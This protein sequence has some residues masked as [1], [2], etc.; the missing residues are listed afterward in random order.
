M[1]QHN[2]RQANKIHFSTDIEDQIWYLARKHPDIVRVTEDSISALGLGLFGDTPNDYEI[3]AILYKSTAQVVFLDQSF[4]EKWE[5]QAIAQKKSFFDKVADKALSNLEI[6]SVI[7]GIIGLIVTLY[8]DVRLGKW[9]N[10]EAI[11][12]GFLSGSAI[13]IG[14]ILVVCAFKT[15]LITRLKG[16]NLHF[17]IAGFAIIY[18]ALSSL[19]KK[20]VLL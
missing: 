4:K 9:S 15:E 14:I 18:I 12:R 5:L 20:V 1:Q 13:P 19:F 10:L 3:R 8:L 17:A 7:A 16:N 6:S 2:G 11:L